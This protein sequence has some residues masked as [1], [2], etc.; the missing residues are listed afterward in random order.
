MFVVND[1]AVLKAVCQSWL[2]PRP[3]GRTPC[4]MMSAN[5]STTDA[6]PNM[7]LATAYVRQP[8]S[9]RGSTPTAR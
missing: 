7:T 6:T 5:S 9:M 4:A 2:R 1:T 3:Q 8:C